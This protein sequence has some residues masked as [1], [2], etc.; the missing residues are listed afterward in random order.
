MSKLKIGFVGVGNMGQC[1]HLKNY[2]Q[3]ADCEVVAIAEPRHQLATRVATRY[4]IPRVY[5]D[6]RELL[7]NEHLDGI[8]CSQPFTRHGVLLNDLAGAGVPLFIEKPLASSVAVGEAILTRLEQAKTWVMV[9]YHKR[10]DP[11]TMYAHQ[12]LTQLRAS[13]EL[14]KPRFVRV[15]MPPG[16]WIAGGFEDLIRGDEPVPAAPSDPPDPDMDAA[17]FRDYS[18]FVNYY[19][20][21]VNLLRHLMGEPYTVTYAE[22]S[23]ALMAV[24]GTSGLAGSLEMAP[25]HTTVDWQ[26]S[27]LVGFERGFVSLKLPAPL[28]SFRCGTVTFFSDPGKGY[29]PRTLRPDLPNLHAMKQQ[30]INFLRAIRGELPPTCE[31]HEALEDLRVA[32]EYIRLRDAARA[33]A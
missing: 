5:P 31:A 13:G 19:I 17:T 2:A 29:A 15:T 14:G 10:S 9:G 11:A 7:A 24:R 18:N 30:A 33:G 20:H 4:G 25:Y 32:R 27:A 26:E 21:Q 23:G 6:H 12:Q 22:A 16:D 3:L 1:A 8:V 28:A